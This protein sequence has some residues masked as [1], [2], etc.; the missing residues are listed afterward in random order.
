MRR[1]VPTT[2]MVEISGRAVITDLRYA[3]WCLALVPA[4]ERGAGGAFVAPEV[5][6]GEAGGPGG[7]GDTGGAGAYPP[8][9]GQEPPPAPPGPL[10]ARGGRPPPPP[11]PE[12]GRLGR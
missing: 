5:R 6:A 7:G 11:G 8:P 10:P 12:R 4:E 3:D 9:P 1:I 2:L